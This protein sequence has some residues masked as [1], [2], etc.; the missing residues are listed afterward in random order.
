MMMKRNLLFTAVTALFLSACGGGGGS[1]T[2]APAAPAS[3]ASGAGSAAAAPAATGELNIYNWSDYVDPD[4]VAAFEKENGVTVRYDYYDSNE[5]LEAKVLT[6]KSGYD[7][8]A[9]SIVSVGRQIQAGAYQPIDK[10]QISNWDNIDPELLK[11]MDQ[12]DP[13]NKY[14]V[15]YFWGINTVGINK[16]KVAKALGDTPMPENTWD[17]VFKP[18]YTAKLKSCGISFF[19]SP[20]ELFPLALHYLGK[21][22]NS[23]NVDDLKAAADL[24]KA[25]RGDVKRFSSSGYIDDMARGDLCVATGYGGDLHIAQTR[26][27]EANNGVKIDVLVPATGVGVWVDSFMIPKDAANVANAHKYINYTLDAKVAAKNADFVSYA[28][29]SKPAREL[30]KP[31]YAQD[32]SIFPSPEVMSKSFVI[33]P[34]SPDAVKQSV[35]L[36]QQLKAGK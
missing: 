4:T 34:K 2:S 17:L 12:V 23:E 22:A 32:P 13:G 33:L 3:D 29:A 16:D 31:E 20:A 1:Q 35:R 36:W 27:N 6:G 5:T 14:A 30:M 7:L 19:D 8:V 10:S 26:A 28:P 25:V 9:P 11:L 18:E 24:L 21:D 15:P